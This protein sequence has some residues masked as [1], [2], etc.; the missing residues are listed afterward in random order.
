MV[1]LKN[2]ADGIPLLDLIKKINHN[3]TAQLEGLLAND[4]LSEAAFQYKAHKGRKFDIGLNL[5]TLISTQYRKENLHSDILREIL[6][7]KGLH[8]EG[9]KFL[10]LFLQYLHIHPKSIQF[11]ADDYQQCVVDREV[12][13]I[14]IAV[15]DVKSRKAIIIENKINNAPDMI[16]QIPRYVE[17]LE[18]QGYTIDAVVYLILAGNKQPY[19]HDWTEAEREAILNKILPICAFDE[20]S[21][22]LYNGWLLNCEAQAENIDTAFLFRHYNKLI[23]KLGGNRMNQPL[24]E[25]FLSNMLQGN[26]YQIANAL[27]DMLDELIKF[28]RDKIIDEFKHRSLPF[29]S[30]RD[31]NN[32]AVIDSYSSGNQNFAVDVIVEKNMY[33]VQFFERVFNSKSDNKDEANPA[34]AV[35]EDIGLVNDFFPS[36]KRMEIQFAFPEQEIELYDFLKRFIQAINKYSRKGK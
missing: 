18:K 28:R 36:D 16:R 15:K 23:F 4:H 8:K 29:T 20:K 6:D 5:F 10:K 12:G 17:S 19:T 30:V 14:D 27:K 1:S 9:D 7:P 2:F 35:L 26:N 22:D 24:M 13:R 25:E 34:V 32:Y 31:W 33:R 3:S 21:Y 11:N